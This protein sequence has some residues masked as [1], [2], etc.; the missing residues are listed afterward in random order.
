MGACYPIKVYF[1]PKTG[2]QENSTKNSITL[3]VKK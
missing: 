3:Q 2:V 1:V